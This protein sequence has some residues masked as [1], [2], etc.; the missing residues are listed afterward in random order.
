VV[1]IPLPTIDSARGAAAPFAGVAAG[2]ARVVAGLGGCV[3]AGLG[4]PVPLDHPCCGEQR[5]G[6]EAE[7]GAEEGA[8]D[9]PGEQRDDDGH[10]SVHRAVLT[11]VIPGRRW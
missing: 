10:V 5:E 3:V 9:G 6:G 11:V 1:G 7:E 4:A 8:D 2:L